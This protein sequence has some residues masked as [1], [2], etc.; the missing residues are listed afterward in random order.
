MRTIVKPKWSPWW[1]H[2]SGLPWWLSGRESACQCKR[3]GFNS[4]SGEIPHAVE[5]LIVH[6]YEPVLWSPGLK[7]L[8]LRTT[9][10]VLCDKRNHRKE[11]PEH[12]SED[13]DKN[14][15]IKMKRGALR[16]WSAR[17]GSHGHP[18]PRLRWSWLIEPASG[19]IVAL[20][21]FLSSVQAASRGT[22]STSVFYGLC[23]LWN[24]V[25]YPTIKCLCR[26]REMTTWNNPLR[27]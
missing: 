15:Y 3:H 7:L 23:D 17:R 6:N 2:P 12:C 20:I 26:M 11:K 18:R 1:K 24:K 10:H 4:W 9:N 5:Q 21:P 13:P 27:H 25:W 14:K 16:R 8:S 22:T 19:L